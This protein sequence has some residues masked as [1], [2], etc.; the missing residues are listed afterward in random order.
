M[1]PDCVQ[2]RGGA[3]VRKFELLWLRS[4]LALSC[5]DEAVGFRMSVKVLSYP[6]HL[7]VEG[8]GLSEQVADGRDGVLA[9]SMCQ[10]YTSF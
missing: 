10:S 8:F 6:D 2:R 1:N 4:L 3:D 7:K 9:S 5:W